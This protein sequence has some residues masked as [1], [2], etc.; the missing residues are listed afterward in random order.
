MSA[1]RPSRSAPASAS[2]ATAV[3]GCVPLMSASPSFGASVTGCKAGPCQRV[4]SRKHRRIMITKRRFAFADQHE[5]EVRER[6]EVAA[7][8]DRSAGRHARVHAAD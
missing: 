8:A 2:A 1:A 6:R 3:D 5:R 7:R 4:A